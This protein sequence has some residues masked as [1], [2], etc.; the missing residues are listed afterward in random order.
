[1]AV[2]EISALSATSPAA[3]D[4]TDADLTVDVRC[5]TDPTHSGGRTH[6][7]VLHA[8]WSVDTGHDLDAERFSVAFGG[9][10]SCLD[11]PDKVLPAVRAFVARQLRLT[12]PSIDLVIG[13]GWALLDPFDR[14]CGRGMYSDAGLA[15][16][17]WR[18]LTHV[19]VEHGARP[20]VVKRLAG[21]V[22]T[23][24]GRTVEQRV[25]Y[26]ASALVGRSVKSRADL[27]LLWQA[28]L[29]PELIDVV[30]GKVG[31]GRPLPANFYLGVIS[32]R[33]DLKW[34]HDTATKVPDRELH[35]WLAWTETAHDRAH[36]DSRGD[37]LALGISRRD[38]TVLLATD[39]TPDDVRQLADATG[40][41]RT[42]AA[43]LLATWAD[44]GCFPT[45]PALTATCRYGE[46]H[47]ERISRAA[48]DTVAE[49]SGI[50]GPRE[51]LAFA[52]TMCGAAS[53]AASVI[54]VTQS[55]EPA[56]LLRGIADWESARIRKKPLHA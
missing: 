46:G 30:H 40:R 43:H 48:V 31:H 27:D 17:H 28:G 55:L 9:Y 51:H 42:S 44:A 25:P 6:P 24:H 14:C 56:E 11:L 23:A 1:M 21:Q 12:W 7:I 2:D 10:L 3:P 20:A 37:W 26:G 5:Y 36:P 4:P 39:Y 18:S 15:A 49:L 34:I 13:G 22:L 54:T 45:I 29:T 32:R 8:D 33:P 52:L 53:L 41:T 47:P 35:D 50:P 16:Q 38:V 19:A